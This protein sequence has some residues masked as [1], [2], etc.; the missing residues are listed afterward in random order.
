MDS[1][2][3]VS[4]L[5]SWAV[6]SVF[7]LV[8]SYSVVLSLWVC[9]LCINVLR[10]VLQSVFRTYWDSVSM[11][12]IVYVICFTPLQ[13]DLEKYEGLSVSAYGGRESWV[14]R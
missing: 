13:V 5:I 14:W 7:M 10:H 4:L 8:T 6:V 9:Q 3:R 2:M 12:C 1:Q 11:L